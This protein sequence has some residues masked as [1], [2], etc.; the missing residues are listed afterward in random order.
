[1]HREKHSNSYELVYGWLTNYIVKKASP[2]LM[3]IGV[4]PNHITLFNVYLSLA[5]FGFIMLKMFFLAAFMLLV[6]AFID[7]L[8]GSYARYTNQVS[9]LG[10]KLDRMIDAFSFICLFIG[11]SRWSLA[12]YYGL[13]IYFSDLIVFNYW[14][15]KFKSLDQELPRKNTVWNYVIGATAERFLC[16]GALILSAIY[17]KE[18]V[19]ILYIMGYYSLQIYRNIYLIQRYRRDYHKL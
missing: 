4:T 10:R 16:S 8:D 15:K 1:M 19:L 7:G 14:I 6:I 3:E 11:V 5:L 9:E 13:I 2:K 12:G 18:V 17:K